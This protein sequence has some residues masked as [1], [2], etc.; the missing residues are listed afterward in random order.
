M[1]PKTSLSKQ[2]NFHNPQTPSS[3]SFHIFL[4]KT[5]RFL[6][7]EKN[8]LVEEIKKLAKGQGVV[9]N[10]N[11]IPKVI[12]AIQSIDYR[13]YKNDLRKII[14]KNDRSEESSSY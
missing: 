7:G 6:R 2:K 4:K 5:I 9:E 8:I 3:K 13:H 11:K 1:G 12:E 10:K 14:A